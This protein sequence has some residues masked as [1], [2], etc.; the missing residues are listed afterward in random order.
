[1]IARLRGTRV[2]VE[3]DKVK[4]GK[5]GRAIEHNSLRDQAH[6]DSR[7]HRLGSEN[8]REPVPN[9]APSPLTFFLACQLPSGKNQVKITRTGRRYPDKNFV[10]WRAKALAAIGGVPAPFPGPVQ[11]IVHYVPG[12]RIRRDLPGLLDALCHLLERAGIVRDDA[13]VKSL[14]WQE[15]PVEPKHPRC[16]V[17]IKPI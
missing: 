7:V 12:D 4:G 14:V 17:S 13:Q 2:T 6:L 3:E 11:M 10:H 1:M 5:G 8:S 9:P 16:R 15:Y